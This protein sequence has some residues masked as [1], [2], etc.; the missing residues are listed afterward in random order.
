MKPKKLLGLSQS[1]KDSDLGPYSGGQY[2]SPSGKT[3]KL[4]VI[5]SSEL[6]T[7]LNAEKVIAGKIAAIIP[8]DDPLP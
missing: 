6:T 7:G 5:R 3:I 2:T 1:I 8:F 4:Q